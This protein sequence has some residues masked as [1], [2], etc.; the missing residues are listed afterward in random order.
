MI[1]PALSHVV[2]EA[3]TTIGSSLIASM[4]IKSRFL[5]NLILP[6]FISTKNRDMTR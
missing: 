6:G 2:P 1:V 3:I 4:C 5:G